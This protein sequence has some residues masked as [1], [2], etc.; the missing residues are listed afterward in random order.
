MGSL[1]GAILEVL[2][3]ADGPL[4]P[5]EVLEALRLEPPVSYATVLTIL[6]RLWRKGM[7]QREQVG[8][9][10]MYRPSRSR[11]EQVAATMADAFEAAGDPKAALGHFVHQLSA[12]QE[13]VLRRVLRRR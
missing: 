1:E 3:C 5:G 13:S 9:A 7:V 2:W 11:D 4:K 12:E 8:K 10:H 6:R